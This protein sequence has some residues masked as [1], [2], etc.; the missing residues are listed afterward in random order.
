[1]AQH[2]KTHFFPPGEKPWQTRRSDEFVLKI[3]NRKKNQEKQE[4]NLKHLL[5]HSS[6]VHSVVSKRLITEE[7][8][9]YTDTSERSSRG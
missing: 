5:N 1:M 9:T 7:L 3:S 8:P 4:E 2:I 6:S